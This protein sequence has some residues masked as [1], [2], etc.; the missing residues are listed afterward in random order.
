MTTPEYLV[1]TSAIVRMLQDDGDANGW[2]AVAQSGRIAL[3]ELTR[4]EFLYSARSQAHRTAM[5][6][7]LDALFPTQFLPDDSFRRA[8]QVQ[9]RLTEL[10]QHRSAGAVDL[11]LAAAAELSHRTVLHCDHDFETIA[12][13]TGQ[14]VCMVTGPEA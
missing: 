9:D 1:D 8:E 13:V 4:L 14:P 5:M 6:E 10:G 2:E 3:L 7:V 12:R 11:V